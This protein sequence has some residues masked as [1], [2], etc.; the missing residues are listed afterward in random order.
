LNLGFGFMCFE[1]KKLM[2]TAGEGKESN[3]FNHED[4]LCGVSLWT[5]AWP[6]KIPFEYRRATIGGVITIDSMPFILTAAHVFYPDDCDDEDDEASI[7]PAVS[8]RYSDMM[9]SPEL[10]EASDIISRSHGGIL[11]H[12]RHKEVFVFQ[13]PQYMED[14]HHSVQFGSGSSFS[15]G[16]KRFG[17]LNRHSIPYDIERVICPDLDW[18]LV[19]PDSLGTCK[20]NNFKTPAGNIVSLNSISLGS[21]AGSAVVVVAGNSGVF[22]AQ[23]SRRVE[24][25]ILPGSMRMQEVWTIE[26]VCRA[27]CCSLCCLLSTNA[28]LHQGRG[29]AAL[30]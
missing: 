2:L 17:Y 20:P 18:A 23:A 6:Q 26:S 8:M 30:G 12:L 9:N 28:G 29:T 11:D 4:S 14:D 27:S 24:G 5:P 7:S 16:L 10:S 22:E 13:R 19:T 1:D 25:I 15:D 3:T 21:P